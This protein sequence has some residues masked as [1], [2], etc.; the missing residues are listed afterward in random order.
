[1]SEWTPEYVDMLF[2]K[3]KKWSV[4]I[5]VLLIT[6]CAGRMVQ[7]EEKT[8]EGVAKGFV[9]AMMTTDAQT[10]VS[11]LS[12]ELYAEKIAQGQFATKAIYVEYMENV[13]DGL[14]KTYTGEYGKKWSYSINIIDSYDGIPKE[15]SGVT[16][17]KYRVVVLEVK[18]KDKVLWVEKEGSEYISIVLKK[19]SDGWYIH[20]VEDT[21]I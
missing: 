15:D 16:P 10:Y 13:L 3:I 6:C 20:F 19:Q 21:Y 14:I 1:M 9:E 17:G 11:L 7:E 5:I 8:P 12:D 4:V 2:E 18:H